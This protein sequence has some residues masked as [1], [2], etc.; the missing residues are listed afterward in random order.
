MTIFDYS[1]LAILV[2]SILLSVVRGVVRELLSLAGWVVA[3][4]VA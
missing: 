3:F 2:V 4:M 1:V